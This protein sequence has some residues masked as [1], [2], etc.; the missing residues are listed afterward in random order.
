MKKEHELVKAILAK[1]P[2]TRDDDFLLY[3]YVCFNL[4]EDI[5]DLTFG[6]IVKDHVEL[7]MP[8]YESVTRW[9]R[10]LQETDP[11]L[12]GKAYARRKN[13]QEEYKKKFGGTN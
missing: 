5:W 12:R 9:R 8:S 6:E 7:E 4:N 13:L 3:G 1:Y 2:E 10:K 11:S